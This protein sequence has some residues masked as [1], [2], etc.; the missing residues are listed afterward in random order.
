MHNVAALFLRGEYVGELNDVP[1][2]ADE[3]K[4]AVIQKCI[5][6]RDMLKR[7]GA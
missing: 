6:Y 4:Q 2:P 5:P 7:K 1:D 3:V